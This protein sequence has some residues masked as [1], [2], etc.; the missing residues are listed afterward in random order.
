[1]KLGDLVK[2]K[3]NSLKENVLIRHV[4]LW[5]KNEEWNEAGFFKWNEVGCIIET[6][7]ELHYMITSTGNYGWVFHSM[8]EKA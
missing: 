6:G 8:I 2:L 7:P 4:R 3:K 1:M 5:E